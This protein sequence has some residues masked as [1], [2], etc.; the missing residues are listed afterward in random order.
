MEYRTKAGSRI[1][2]KEK[3]GRFIVTYNGTQIAEAETLAAARRIALVEARSADR[4][5][6]VPTA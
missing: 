6:L 4:W 5:E 3:A 1:T 2:V